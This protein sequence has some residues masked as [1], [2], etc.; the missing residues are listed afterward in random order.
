MAL[1]REVVDLRRANLADQT[2]E[3]V[4]VGHIAMMQHERPVHVVDVTVQM[5]D[6]LRAE[7]ART[8]HKTMHLVPL[9]EKEFG[10]I[11]A[12]LAGNPGDQRSS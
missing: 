12:I 7:A 10:K 1:R 11:G 6:P 3:T 4:A 8:A 5:L 9:V 2:G